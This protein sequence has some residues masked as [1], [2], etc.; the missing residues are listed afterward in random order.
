MSK[1]PP[2][3]S[4]HKGVEERLEKIAASIDKTN[5][6]A[7]RTHWP[8]L[9]LLTLGFAAIALPLWRG[10]FSPP[11]IQRQ[12][13]CYAQVVPPKALG[14]LEFI[15]PTFD[16]AKHERCNFADHCRDGSKWHPVGS[17][18]SI[19]EFLKENHKIVF[20]QLHTGHDVDELNTSAQQKYKSNLGLASARHEFLREMLGNSVPIFV[21]ITA[22]HKEK[23]K[24]IDRTPRLTAVFYAQ[25]Q[26]TPLPALQL[27]PCPTLTATEPRKL[28]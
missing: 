28:K 8:L 20:W 19:S 26:P 14:S 6:A 1:F 7:S 2:P 24:D 3:N 17:K 22:G 13:Q 27:I 9:L 23:Q 25:D 21:A 4:E 12:D 16:S 18:N 10:L 15:G 5:G 11:I